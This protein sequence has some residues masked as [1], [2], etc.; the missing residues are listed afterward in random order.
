MAVADYTSVRI[1][2]DVLD[3]ID[4]VVYSATG[5]RVKLQE[6]VSDAVKEKLDA[7]KITADQKKKKAS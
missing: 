4:S 7:Y 5:L 1:R 2:K 6:F 3:Q